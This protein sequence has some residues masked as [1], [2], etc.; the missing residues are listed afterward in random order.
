M[1]SRVLAKPFWRSTPI[2]LGAGLA[3]RLPSLVWL[4]SPIRYC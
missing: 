1:T 3:T 4:A 2:C